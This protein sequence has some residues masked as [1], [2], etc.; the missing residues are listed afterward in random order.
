MNSDPRTVRSTSCLIRPLHPSDARALSD[1]LGEPTILHCGHFEPA[2]E[3]PV[4]QTFARQPEGEQHRLVAAKDGH[5][6]GLGILERP[7]SSR[8]AHLGKVSLLVIPDI[9]GQEI[10]A[11]LLDALID[12]AETWLN[13]KRLESVIPANATAVQ[14]IFAQAGF[15]AEGT[16][17]KSLYGD[18]QFQDEVLLARLRGFEDLDGAKRRPA[19]EPPKQPARKVSNLLIRPMADEDVDDLYDIFRAPE[20]CRTTLQLPSQELWL[21]H[22]RVR[23]RSADIRRLVAVAD[24]RIVGTITLR[25]HAHRCRVHAAELGLMVHPDHW[26]QGIG[27][28][29]MTRM[30]ELADRWLNLTRIDLV[31][32]TDNSAGIRLYDKFDFVVEGTKAFHTYGDGGWVDSYIM[33]RVV[34]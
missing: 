30:L 21:T 8:M 18:G 9:H 29:L 3:F 16:L 7:A 12:I 10:G 6:V 1:L 13:L 24:E 15:I 11:D 25:P 28:R 27:S 17:K 34:D 32:Q 19:L 31:V 20:N 23:E 5:L 2:A 14:H 33:A 4:F 22:Q 26:G